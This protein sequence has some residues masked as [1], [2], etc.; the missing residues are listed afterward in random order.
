[1]IHEKLRGIPHIRYIN[2]D[3]R[4]K[5]NNLLEDEFSKYGITDYKRLSASTYSATKLRSNWDDFIHTPS[6]HAP[7]YTSIL[8][9]QLH[10]IIDWYQQEVS[11]TCLILEDDLSFDLV[12]H[13]TFDWE[14]LMSYIPKN[15]DCVQFHILGLKYMQMNLHRRTNN[16]QGATCYMINRRYAKKLIDIHWIDGK[17]KFHENYGMSELFPKFYY[18]SPDYVPYE[19]GITYSMPIFTTNRT[20][21]YVSDAHESHINKHAIVADSCVRKWWKNEASKY[22]PSDIF[23]INTP[24]LKEMIFKIGDGQQSWT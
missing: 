24:K 14:T 6:T 4:P 22:Q 13:W 3:E 5:R 23:S 18:Q 16:N 9:N 12:E 20:L 10:S 8:V 2:L 1:M 7:R 19:I 15:W 11:E 17:L 21:K